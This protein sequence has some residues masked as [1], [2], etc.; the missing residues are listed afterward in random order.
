L[1]KLGDLRRQAANRKAGIGDRFEAH[2]RHP[3]NEHLD[4]YRRELLAR[5]NEP[6]YVRLVVTRLRALFDGCGFLRISELSLSQVADGLA[7]QRRDERLDVALPEGQEEVTR[8]QA[9][10]LLGMAPTAFRDAVRRHRLS[11]VGKGP[12]RRFPR[13]T[14]EAV[15]DLQGRGSSVQT[16]NYHVSHLKSICRWLVKDRRVAESPAEHL[17]AVDADAD[18]RRAR[19]ELTAEELRRLLSAA[20]SST[21][22]FRGLAGEA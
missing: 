6:R 2:A 5:N 20:R 9:S 11:T 12:A 16:T 15:R 10:G 14:F 21:K 17:E 8:A 22:S 4:D 3:L 13:Q 7:S 19:R 1:A 18:R